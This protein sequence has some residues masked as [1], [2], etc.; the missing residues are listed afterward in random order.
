MLLC[1]CVHGC[2]VS[3][4][5][6]CVLMVHS[7]SDGTKD[8]Y[9]SIVAMREGARKAQRKSVEVTTTDPPP[10]AC[11]PILS[12]L[13][14]SVCLGAVSDDFEKAATKYVEEYAKKNGTSHVT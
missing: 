12:I 5:H 3:V 13:N 4:V 14:P 6:I 9:E 11:D 8:F 7:Q 10:R 1:V 2:P